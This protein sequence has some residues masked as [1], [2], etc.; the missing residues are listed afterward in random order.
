MDTLATHSNTGVYGSEEA[1]LNA[2]VRRLKHGIRPSRIYLVGGRA[3][4]K[5]YPGS[6]F[7]FVVVTRAED[8]E[9]GSD[10]EYVSHPLRHTG[11]NVEL[12]PVRAN[13]L[14][15]GIGTNVRPSM[16]LIKNGRLLFSV[17]D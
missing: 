3:D 9:K 7:Q 17:E 8:G 5:Y 11:V 1:A 6:P 13:E 2:V 4:G 12:I 10:C 16:K 15:R 14:Q